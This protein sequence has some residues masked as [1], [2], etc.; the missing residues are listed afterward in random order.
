M[1]EKPEKKSMSVKEVADLWGVTSETVLNWIR[2]SELA[3]VNVS[4]SLRSKKPRFRITCEALAA[5]EAARSATPPPPRAAR[6]KQ[7]A[8]TV[9]FYP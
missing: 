9:A 1:S 8:D 5:F 7:P 2:A 3:A 6:R 4:R